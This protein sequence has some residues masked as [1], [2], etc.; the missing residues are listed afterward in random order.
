[1]SVSHPPC[2]QAEPPSKMMS[3]WPAAAPHAAPCR[4]R[5]QSRHSTGSHPHTGSHPNAPT[6]LRLT[7]RPPTPPAI[8]LVG[9]RPPGRRHSSSTNS[10]LSSFVILRM[11]GHRR[12]SS[13]H[14]RTSVPTTN[15][16]HASKSYTPVS[17]SQSYVTTPY[18]CLVQSTSPPSRLLPCLIVSFRFLC[19]TCPHCTPLPFSLSPSCPRSDTRHARLRH[20]CSM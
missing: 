18:Q 1:M 10:Q 8:S 14:A 4:L 2:R 3:G 9:W 15:Q 12:P 5:V 11:R 6:Q 13:L 20:V 19:V 16:S 7:Q 17:L